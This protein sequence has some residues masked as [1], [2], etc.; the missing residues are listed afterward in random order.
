M[1]SNHPI[2]L[3]TID[4]KPFPRQTV[5]KKMPMSHTLEALYLVN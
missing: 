3:K 4:G 2:N 5:E 1:S